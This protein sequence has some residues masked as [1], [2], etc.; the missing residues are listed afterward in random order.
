MNLERSSDQGTCHT[1]VGASAV[2]QVVE[3]TTLIASQTAAVDL[4]EWKCDVMF[5]LSRVHLA[6]PGLTI[7]N[8]I[9]KES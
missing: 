9:D 3:R 5:L 4:L 7:F 2:S 6:S 8:L 1:G